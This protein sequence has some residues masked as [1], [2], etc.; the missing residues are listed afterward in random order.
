MAKGLE[1]IERVR[2]RQAATFRRLKP[3]RL[4]HPLKFMNLG[5]KVRH[6]CKNTTKI[7]FE[8]FD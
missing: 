4:T 8:Y 7:G 1:L 5:G 3:Y 6:T 2:K